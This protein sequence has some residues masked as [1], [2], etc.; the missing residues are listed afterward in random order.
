MLKKLVLLLCVL[1]MPRLGLLVALRL[2]WATL[3]APTRAWLI[4]IA[5]DDLMNVV[6]NGWLGQTISYR[7][8][9]ADIE[10]KRWGCVLCRWLDAAEQGHCTKALTDSK[11]N[12]FH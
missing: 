7:A 9:V 10:G 5:L 2:L 4:V 6:C 11:Q 1:L 8:A 12:L 3:T